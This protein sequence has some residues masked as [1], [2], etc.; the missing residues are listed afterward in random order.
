MVNS[1]LSFLSSVSF[2]MILGMLLLFLVALAFSLI[3]I[4]L[5]ILT[6]FGFLPTVVAIAI[7]NYEE[8]VLS[9]I[10]GLFNILGS[11]NFFTQI[12]LNIQEI[13]QISYIIIFTSNTWLVIY[14]SCAFGLF[15]YMLMPRIVYYFI[16]TE[17]IDLVDK[18]KKDLD[19]IYNEF[20]EKDVKI[21]IVKNRFK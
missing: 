19:D 13:E 14:T 16:Y 11:L 17:K 12:L 9:K 3:S 4:N 20:G 15:L 21:S 10:I 5:S 6:F 1:S 8:K 7:D 2:K 18:L